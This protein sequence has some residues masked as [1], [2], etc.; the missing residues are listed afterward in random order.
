M[1][2]HCPVYL[3][4]SLSKVVRG[5]GFWRLNN[6]FLKEPEYV[7][8]LNN[9]IERVIKQYSKNS[10]GNNSPSQE[11]ALHPFLIS[12]T[13][14]HDVLLLES[15]SHT[16]KYASNQKKKLLKRTE[17]LNRKIDEKA[18]SIDPEDMEMVNYMKQ[19]VQ[20]L[21]DEREMAIARK[22]FV[23]MQLEGERPTQYFCKMNKKFQAK[24]QFEEIHLEEV[25]Q[26]GK[27]VTKVIRDQEE[28]EKRS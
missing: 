4:L 7:F 2:D 11:P 17:E 23:R 5:R 27:E 3:H 20:N 6:D 8:G 26:R 21:E 16:L 9:T 19:E 14:L 28:T 1:S 22:C 15:R 13:L 18:D 24:A 25:D 10:N 12:H